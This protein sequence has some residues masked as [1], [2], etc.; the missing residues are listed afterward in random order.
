M[1][2]QRIYTFDEDAIREV[3]REIQQLRHKVRHLLKQQALR[4][5]RPSPEVALAELGDQGI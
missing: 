2:K 1:S 4:S 5:W 3:K